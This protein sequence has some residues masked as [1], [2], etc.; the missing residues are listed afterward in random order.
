MQVLLKDHQAAPDRGMVL[1]RAT[2]RTGERLGL[3]GREL[4][5][6]L[7]VSEPT[8]SR[9][10]KGAYILEDGTKPYEL[11][12]LLVRLF[13]SLDAISGGDEGVARTWM[14]TENSALEA[15]PADRI[16]SITGLIDVVQYLDARRAPL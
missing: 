10:R 1:T 2:L 12:A 15:R 3:S 8:I 13:R 9:M 14:R 11:A 7:G 6:A 16:S 5:Q 4:A